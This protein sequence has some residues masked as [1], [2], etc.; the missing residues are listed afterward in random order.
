MT[1]APFFSMAQ[2]YR[3]LAGALSLAA[4]PWLAHRVRNGKEDPARLGERYGLTARARPAGPVVWCHGASVGEAQTLLVLI[5]ALT[6]RGHGVVLTSG[7][8][9]SAALM[10]ERLPA[11]AVHQYLPLDRGPWVRRFLDHWRPHLVVWSE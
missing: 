4:P 10:A 5:A 2:A 11:G 1:R 3:L 9:T 8:V 7:T 6:A